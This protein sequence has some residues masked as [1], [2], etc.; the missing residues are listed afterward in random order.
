MQKFHEKKEAL[1]KLVERN[2]TLT[3]VAL[4]W[5]GKDTM[6]KRFL[7]ELSVEWSGDFR[8]KEEDWDT[9]ATITTFIHSSQPSERWRGMKKM[10]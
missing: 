2:A 9:I 3:L 5:D 7:M 1:P 6:Q 4:Q 10:L 8:Q